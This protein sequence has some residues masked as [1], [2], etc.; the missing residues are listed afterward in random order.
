[1]RQDRRLPLPVSETYSLVNAHTVHC[2]FPSDAGLS[3]ASQRYRYPFYNREGTVV[4]GWKDTSIYRRLRHGKALREWMEDDFV[5][6]VPAVVKRA[7]LR[8][9]HIPGAVWI[10]T[11]TFQGDTTAFLA[12]FASHVVSLE[13]GRE[14]FAKAQARFSDN[15][16]VQI[17]NAP[18]ETAFPGLL[19]D[20]EGP[21]CFWLDGHYSG[22][23]TFQGETD[24][25][26][27][28]EMDAIEA[29]LP[30]LGSVAVLIDDIRLFDSKNPI[31]SGYPS[32]DVVVDWARRCGLNWKIE[33]DIF[34]ATR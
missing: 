29:A 25:P 3:T 11:G 9:H 18:S 4:M 15:P 10:E 28:G 5:V 17:I 26:I 16:A 14:L 32:L 31:H 13:P 33:H 21:V 30:R 34:I 19:S 24:T 7:V 27:G 12:R 8:R 6:P 1:M 22:G 23:S 2:A 20:L